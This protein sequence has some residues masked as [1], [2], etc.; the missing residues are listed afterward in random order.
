MYAEGMSVQVAASVA[1]G[2]LDVVEQ[3]GIMTYLL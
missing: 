2:Y 3:A 1:I